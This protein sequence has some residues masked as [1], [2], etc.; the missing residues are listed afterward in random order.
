MKNFVPPFYLSNLL[1]QA[2]GVDR[3]NK[4]LSRLHAA[5]KEIA[6]LVP[7]APLRLSPIV[8]QRMPSIFSKELVSS[9]YTSSKRVQ[10]SSNCF[11]LDTTPLDEYVVFRAM[12]CQIALISVVIIHC[13]L[14][15]VI[16]F[17]I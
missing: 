17:I 16:K 14:A 13:L 7:L 2:N 5:F 8:V 6:D 1:K 12:K 9:I 11:L 15:N 10:G 4:V 3:K